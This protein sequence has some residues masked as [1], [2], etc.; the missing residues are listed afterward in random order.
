M[1]KQENDSERL[2]KPAFM[3]EPSL[4]ASNLDI[5]SETVMDRTALNDT[6]ELYPNSGMDVFS[7]VA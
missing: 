7:F 5:L 3:K 2:R 4:G 6:S 1:H